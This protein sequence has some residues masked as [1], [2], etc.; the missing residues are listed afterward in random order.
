MII[1]RQS[2]LA[3]A[4]VYECVNCG[5][6]REEALVSSTDNVREETFV[7]STEDMREEARDIQQPL[8]ITRECSGWPKHVKGCEGY[9]TSDD[10]DDTSRQIQ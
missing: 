5:S 4:N 9:V 10:D 8:V 6:S 3:V 1:T 7:S 2:S